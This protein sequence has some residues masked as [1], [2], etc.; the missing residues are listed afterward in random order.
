MN[1]ALSP[2]RPSYKPRMQSACESRP[3]VLG[4]LIG[5]QEWP[6]GTWVGG[7]R[8]QGCLGSTFIADVTGSRQRVLGGREMRAAGARVAGRSRE[9]GCHGAA[10][11]RGEEG[12]DPGPASFRA[13]GGRRARLW[14]GGEREAK[15]PRA[16]LRFEPRTD[17]PV[18]TPAVDGAGRPRAEWSGRSQK[19][20][21]V[22]AARATPARGPPPRAHRPHDPLLQSAGPRAFH[23][24]SG[25]RSDRQPVAAIL[26][27]PEVLRRKRKRGVSGEP[28][29]SWAGGGGAGRGRPTH[30]R[31]LQH[32]LH[33]PVAVGDAVPQQ[34]LRGEEDHC[35]RRPAPA[36]NRARAAGARALP[37][38]RQ[39][40]RDFRG[41]ATALVRMLAGGGLG[42]HFSRYVT[43]VRVML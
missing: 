16:E 19:L 39:P 12:R 4:A 41:A 25:H 3:V 14:T 22:R 38:Q 6:R 18:Q 42:A 37:G 35:A 17:G 5:S 30:P 26:P 1:R 34:E 23:K 31:V 36:L 2:P 9:A 20:P 32:L 10:G 11:L 21:A 29:G 27:S 43:A 28:K 7:Q 40:G 15:D 8:H 13:W 33:P 24:R